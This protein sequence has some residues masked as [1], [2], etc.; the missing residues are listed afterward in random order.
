MASLPYISVQPNLPEVVQDIASDS[1]DIQVE[2]VWI[3]A[4][5]LNSPSGSIHAKVPVLAAKDDGTPET[6]GG[7]RFDTA[8][9]S[10]TSSREGEGEGGGSGGLRIQRVADPT[11]AEGRVGGVRGSSGFDLLVSTPASLSATDDTAMQV[12]AEPSQP[13]QNQPIQ[14]RLEEKSAR[15]ARTLQSTIRL[16]A[17]VRIRFPVSSVTRALPALGTGKVND[18]Y[19]NYPTI[20]AF[21]VSPTANGLYVAG[22]AEGQLFIGCWKPFDEQRVREEYVA[23][24]SDAD[25]LVLQGIG[26]DQQ[27]QA[28]GEGLE[29]RLEQEAHLRIAIST[30]RRAAAKK[31]QLQGHVG[32]IRSVRFFPS[33]KVVLSTSSDLTARVW[34][35]GTGENARTLTGHKRAVTCSAIVGRGRTVVTASL[36][37][38]ARLYELA[39]PK[40]IRMYAAERFSPVHSL[41]LLPPAP[42]GHAGEDAEQTEMLMG[43]GSGCWQ[44]TNLAS[45]QTELL[46][47]PFLFPPGPAPQASDTWSQTKTKSVSAIAATDRFVVTGTVDGV[48][49]VWDLDLLRHKN[50]EPMDAD[51]PAE[52]LPRAI[53]EAEQKAAQVVAQV[54]FAQVA[55]W[56]RNNATV[57]CISVS[58]PNT[59]NTPDTPDTPDSPTATTLLI[60]V[61]T[62]D[63]LPY[64]VALD[65][66]SN[67]NSTS[68]FTQGLQNLRIP[69][70]TTEFATWDCDPTTFIGSSPEGRTVVAG[71]EGRISFY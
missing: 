38:T 18:N 59:S 22:G 44:M 45:A 47:Q 11:V 68:N 4:Y 12:D 27:A 51:D 46:V 70:L 42:S 20:E 55:A 52:V 37:G 57:N 34:D 58:T 25:R 31:V 7:F 69:T 64:R 36:D 23:G 30:S 71:A 8:S 50:Q 13:K 24:L 65:L 56:K 63:G 39:T 2:K 3:S 40:Q 66:D 5:A 28:G 43:L 9:N 60:D 54:P 1:S 49:S 10:N 6:R 14:A 41:A 53:E 32:D 29:K 67:S 62:Q 48:V 17:P 21:D 61:A 16:D 26:P 35:A 19:T 15:S 33:G